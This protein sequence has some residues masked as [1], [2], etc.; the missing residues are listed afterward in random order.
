VKAKK[1]SIGNQL[2]LSDGI[3]LP[4]DER[5][6]VCVIQEDEIQDEVSY[7]ILD[8]HTLNVVWEVLYA[9]TVLTISTTLPPFFSNKITLINACNQG[10][11][12]CRTH[13]MIELKKKTS[14]LCGALLPL[15][16]QKEFQ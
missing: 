1:A 2:L 3:R 7:S 16:L 12:V 11:I 14:W 13:R 15:K 6:C 5:L 10:K 9:V 8:G 4:R